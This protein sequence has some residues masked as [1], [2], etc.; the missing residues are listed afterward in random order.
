MGYTADLEAAVALPY[1]VRMEISGPLGIKL[2]L[3]ILNKEWVMLFV[4][5]EKTVFRFPAAELKKDSLRRERF[6]KLLPVP[7]IP[8]LYMNSL[9][10]R[11]GLPQ[12]N[13]GI[14]CD[15]NEELNVY[16]VRVPKTSDSTKGG[17][18]V[19]LDPVQFVPLREYYFDGLLPDLNG[20]VGRATS[21]VHYSRLLGD[22][23]N[24][25]PSKIE[26]G[27]RNGRDLRFTWQSAERWT[28]VDEKVFDWQPPA[29]IKI[30][31]Y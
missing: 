13:S 30:Q 19:W 5:R 8:D 22:G 16:R 18:I 2:G 31:D 17:R 3:L 12:K 23:A 7:L 27:S 6:L 14:R 10:T 25:F 15:Y 4:P 1:F 28:S 26:F 21:Q 20:D 11:V 29:S 9:L 24:A